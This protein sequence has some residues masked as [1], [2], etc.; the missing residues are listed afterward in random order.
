MKKNFFFLALGFVPLLQAEPEVQEEK[1]LW[2][3]KLKTQPCGNDPFLG[4]LTQKPRRP[5]F[6][7]LPLASMGTQCT[8][9]PLL[10]LFIP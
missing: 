3:L 5:T 4:T 9:V 2:V 8:F 7:I 6:Q 10:L 1:A